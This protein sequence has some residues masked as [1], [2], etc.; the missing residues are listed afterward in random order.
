MSVPALNLAQQIEAEHQAAIGAAQ[1]ADEMARA[2]L[3]H[4]A[5]CGDMLLKAQAEIAGDWGQWVEANL[6]FGQRQA[7]KYAR[8]SRAAR[9]KP[10][11]L[12]S[13]STLDAALSAIASP[14]KHP[15]A[16]G[17]G[18]VEWYTPGSY[19]E[20]ARQVMGEFDL[21]PATS[22][23][24]QE[25]VQARNYFTKD[26]DGLTQPWHGKIWCNPPYCDAGKF[27]DKLLAE[28]GAG[29]VSQAVLL[30][31]S[32]TDT[33]WFH[34][35][36]DAC[37]AICFTKGRIHFVRPDGDRLEQPAYGSAFIYFGHQVD[38]FRAAFASH[39]LITIPD[40]AG[41]KPEPKPGLV[42]S[43]CQHVGSGTLIGLSPDTDETAVEITGDGGEFVAVTALINT[44]VV[45]M[46]RAVRA[47]AVDQVLAVIGIEPRGLSWKFLPDPPLGLREMLVDGAA[48]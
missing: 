33:R 25:Q 24:A 40:G 15:H 35:A 46:R 4:A 32:Y 37:A 3:Q 45:G 43:L 10:E 18:S 12:T 44:E 23:V 30:V 21:D 27:V 6:T 29:R 38:R 19:L 17:G 42:S 9:V 41:S 11:L 16:P 36:G 1:S 8:F 13:H 31:N 5:R 34:A 39:G 7:Q 14:V 47:D 26:E 48:P 20:C 2:A 28:I 22:P